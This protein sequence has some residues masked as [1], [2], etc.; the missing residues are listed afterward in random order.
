MYRLSA[1]RSIHLEVTSKCN[2]SC[3]MCLRNVLGGG[4]NPY[5]P[6]T[7]LSLAD[8]QKILP[9]KVVARL[10]RLY[11]CG[12]YGDPVM[13]RDTLEILTYLRSAGPR[14]GLEIFSNGS[15]RG[16]EWW[17]SVAR[18]GVRARFSVDGLGD[19]NAIYRRGTKWDVILRN[20]R[21]FLGEGGIAEWDFIVFKHNE[22]QVEEA[23]ALAKELGFK[24][25]NIK[26]T[27]RFFSNT[28][29]QVKAAQEVQNAKGE[30]EYYLE[31]PENPKYRNSAL[32]KE[33][34]IVDRFGSLKDFFGQTEVDCKV[35]REG[36]LYISAEGLAFPC[37][38]TANQLYPWYAPE[39]GTPIWKLINALP[40][41]LDSL[42]AK[43]RPLSEILDGPFFQKVI[44][45]N[46]IK[47]GIE[48]G[49][50]FVCGKT[51]GRGFDAFQAQFQEKTPT[52]LKAVPPSPETSSRN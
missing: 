16:P 15:A 1:I 33:Q 18:L 34:E 45:E 39:R 17:A 32:L 31:Q 8:I 41:G 46:W 13:A 23:R 10:E 28:K 40:G 6:I 36:S 24:S 11:M 7:E 35:T 3:P 47:K 20:M 19:V 9:E 22:H 4:V 21:A 27:A 43:L 2:A 5:L 51:C 49:R 38:W 29:A 30:I 42:N 12:N 26:K 48:T 25:F 44:P 14:L 52:P 50:L 37:C